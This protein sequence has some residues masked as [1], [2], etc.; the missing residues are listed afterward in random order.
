MRLSGAR[1]AL[2]AT[3]FMVAVGS[4]DGLVPSAA[5]AVDAASAVERLRLPTGFLLTDESFDEQVGSST[6]G[7]LRGIRRY[8]R[9]IGWMFGRAT[10]WWG[11][12]VKRGVFSLAVAIIAALADTGLLNA[13][14]RNGWR[15]ATTYVPMMLYVY[16]RLLFSNGVNI[17]PKLMLVAALIYGAVRKDLIPDRSLYHGRIEDVILIV[18]ATRAFIYACPEA[19]VDGFAERAIS[20]RRRVASFQQ[21]AR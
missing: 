8:W 6:K 16:G 9:T 21:R 10:D 18:L 12:W 11:G 1:Q 20:L 15:T 4:L 2:L 14:R 19:L 3:V 7:L 5:L 17:A 13:W